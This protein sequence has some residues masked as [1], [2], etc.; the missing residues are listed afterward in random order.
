M[1]LSIEL[2]NVNWSSPQIFSQI[3]FFKISEHFGISS[4]DFFL[5]PIFLFQTKKIFCSFFNLILYLHIHLG[6]FYLCRCLCGSY[7]LNFGIFLTR[8][9]P[10][11]WEMPKLSVLVIKPGVSIVCKVTALVPVI[12]YLSLV[13]WGSLRHLVR[14]L[15]FSLAL[16]SAFM[17]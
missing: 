8:T 3:Y 4:Q 5:V 17:K 16:G 15:A 9:D 10:G 14:I 13:E 7:R 11:C 1:S 2:K 12:R 6:L